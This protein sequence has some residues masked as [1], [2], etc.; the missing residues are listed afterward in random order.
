[1]KRT[2][3]VLGLCM[4]VACGD[5]KDDD[6]DNGTEEGA[7]D[8]AVDGTTPDASAPDA[9]VCPAAPAATDPVT[10]QGFSCV[11][12]TSCVHYVG[13]GWT[14]AEAKAECAKGEAQG[15]GK[16]CIYSARTTESTCTSGSGAK[17]SF[18]FS[19]LIASP[20]IC[21]GFVMGTTV[22]K[23]AG[24]WPASYTTLVI[25]AGA[26]DAAPADAANEGG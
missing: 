26:G 7:A 1:M 11:L 19:P 4:A 17:Q 22:N 24:G 23:P 9:F 12:G 5:D 18:I 3:M 8:A 16:S 15:G 21:T 2:W 10:D 20:A 25:D 13:G 6:S 14:E